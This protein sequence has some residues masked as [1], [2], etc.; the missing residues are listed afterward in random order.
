MEIR[1]ISSRDSSIMV[2]CECPRLCLVTLPCYSLFSVLILWRPTT[3]AM[4][5]P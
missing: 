4:A 1:G 3:A 2:D 5:E